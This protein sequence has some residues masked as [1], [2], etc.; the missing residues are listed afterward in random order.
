MTAVALLSEWPFALFPAAV[1]PA[2][3]I[4][5]KGATPRPTTNIADAGRLLQGVELRFD[6]ES[7]AGL[8]ARVPN[9][10]TLQLR[11]VDDPLGV[12]T[13]PKRLGPLAEPLYTDHH[14]APG[15]HDAFLSLSGTHWSSLLLPL[16][17]Y[18]HGYPSLCTARSCGDYSRRP[19]PRQ[20]RPQHYC[21]CAPGP[22]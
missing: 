7:L 16:V 19:P 4:L 1:K 2:P 17:T 13:Q 3:R 14:T 10:R 18:R 21:Y 5:V 8:L 11:G 22:S 6:T 15:R 12:A 20:Y 9:L